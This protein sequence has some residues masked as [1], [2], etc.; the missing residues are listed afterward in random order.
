[1][2]LP[3]ETFYWVGSDDAEGA[4][5]SSFAV[6]EIRKDVDMDDDYRYGGD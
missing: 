3:V 1:M 2:Y 5:E 6:M 4:G